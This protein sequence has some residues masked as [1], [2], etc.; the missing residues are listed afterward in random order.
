M[1]LADGSAALISV[2]TQVYL[3]ATYGEVILS[4]IKVVKH[5]V[6]IIALIALG[7]YLALKLKQKVFGK[8]EPAVETEV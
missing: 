1:V 5:Y 3:F 8:K 2:P 6:L 7:L 4:T